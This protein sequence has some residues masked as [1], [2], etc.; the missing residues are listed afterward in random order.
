MPLARVR[1]HLLSIAKESGKR[2][3]LFA[4]LHLSVCGARYGRSLVQGQLAQR[5][6]IVNTARARVKHRLIAWA[7]GLSVNQIATTSGSRYRSGHRQ[8][9][10]AVQPETGKPP[11][12]LRVKELARLMLIAKGNG[13][14]AQ[15]IARELRTGSGCR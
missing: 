6:W 3:A 4:R 11:V 14:A 8:A 5:R 13:R 12:V 15:Q 2:A 10:S 1:V 7:S 9:D